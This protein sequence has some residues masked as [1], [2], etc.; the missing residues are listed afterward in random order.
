MGTKYILRQYK[1]AFNYLKE[2][3]NYLLAVF[4]I[5]LFS[6]VFGFI[7]P[8]FLSE[9]IKEFIKSIIEKTAG[10]GTFE[11]I[12][13]II[14]NN[15]TS[16]FFGILLG[17]ALG[18]FP[19]LMAMLNGYVLGFVANSAGKTEGYRVLWQLLPHGMFEIPAIVISLGI[20][21]KIGMFI[22]AGR[23]KKQLAYDLTN[24][25][26]VFLLIVL[27]LLLIAGVIE[28]VLIISGR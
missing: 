25:L 18:I 27:P 20:G 10:L 3:K 26:K 9:L 1:V 4:L 5:F 13:F 8:V 15:I 21:I 16:A 28:G 17:V 24:G 2:C 23:K 6:G 22:F 19:I 14:K 11:L 7:F 12:F